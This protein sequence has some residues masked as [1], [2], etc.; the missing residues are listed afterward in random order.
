MKRA[1]RA[2]IAF[3]GAAAC[4][5]GF[6]PAAMADTTARAE[7]TA[8]AA[9]A[10]TAHNC[11]AG[12]SNWVHLYYTT[13]EDHTTPACIGG[14]GRINFPGG[15]EFAKFCAGNNYGY[16]QISGGVYR[17]SA[18]YSFTGPWPVD[19]VAISRWAGNSKCSW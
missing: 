13:A 18:G 1:F 2:S 3:T 5:A 15:K 10:F 16:V 19:G 9:A 17:F 12:E 11:V 4:L 6:A 7:T 14:V 8:A